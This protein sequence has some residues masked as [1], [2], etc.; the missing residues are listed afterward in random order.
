MDSCK[1]LSGKPVST[2]EKTSATA[3]GERIRQVRLARYGGRGASKLARELGISPARYYFYE[4]GAVKPPLHVL[5]KIAQLSGCNYV[6]L[7]TGF[8]S[9]D[10]PEDPLASQAVAEAVQRYG[11]EACMDAIRDETLAIVIQKQRETERELHLA[12]DLLK[13][14][15]KREEALALQVQHLTDRI[16]KLEKG[17]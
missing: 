2:A 13:K 16:A 9:I 5:A 17:K 15:R 10:E 8:G 4:S 11:P 6:W 1:I 3:L 14:S 7:V 12:Q